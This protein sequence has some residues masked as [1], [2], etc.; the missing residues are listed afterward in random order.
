MFQQHRKHIGLLHDWHVDRSITVVGKCT[1]CPGSAMCHLKWTAELLFL[2]V[3][4]LMV[5]H[6]LKWILKL[7]FAGNYE[8]SLFPKMIM[9]MAFQTIS[10]EYSSCHVYFICV[11]RCCTFLYGTHYTL[12]FSI[13]YCF[14]L[15]PH[16]QH[17]IKYAGHTLL[18]AF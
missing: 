15:K 7:L 12:D 5:S 1:H 10:S 16:V 14:Q 8:L 4:F 6:P 17:S 18:V 9:S 13:M 3:G 11:C 2:T